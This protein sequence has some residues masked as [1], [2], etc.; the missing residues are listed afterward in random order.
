MS[1]WFTRRGLTGLL[2]RWICW[3]RGVLKIHL[4]FL[5]VELIAK[6]GVESKAAV[7]WV[8]CQGIV[9]SGSTGMFG[10][11]IGGTILP[12]R[13]IFLIA[14]SLEKGGSRGRH[15]GRGVFPGLLKMNYFV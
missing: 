14:G 12:M 6:V 13:G 8:I 7:F 5:I 10:K 2:G 1:G 11:G 4:G 9:V 3:F 15:R